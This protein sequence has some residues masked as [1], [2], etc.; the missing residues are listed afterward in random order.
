MLV[1]N[2]VGVESLTQIYKTLISLIHK[3]V[4]V[5]VRERER[6]RESDEIDSVCMREKERGADENVSHFI[7]RVEHLDCS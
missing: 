6:E 4:C 2:V 7:F 3:M 1:L 5:W